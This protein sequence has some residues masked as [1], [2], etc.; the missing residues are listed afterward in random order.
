LMADLYDARGNRYL[1]VAP[2]DVAGLPGNPADAGKERGWILPALHGFDLTGDGGKVA[3][4]LLV[5]PFEHRPP[6]NLLIVN[7]DG[8]LAERPNGAATA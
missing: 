5:G 6:F 2:G 1:V 7:T 3:D 8:T 4:G